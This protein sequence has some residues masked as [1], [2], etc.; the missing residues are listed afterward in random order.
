MLISS[1]I[2]LENVSRTPMKPL[3]L[4]NE[5]QLNDPI[6]LPPEMPFPSFTYDEGKMQMPPGKKE[7]SEA[8]ST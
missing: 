6:H 5:R 4:I 2:R 8:P 7:I 3:Q 1:I